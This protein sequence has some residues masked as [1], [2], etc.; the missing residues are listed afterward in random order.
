MEMEKLSE[1]LKNC[2]RCCL[3]VENEMMESS[4]LIEN[5][6]KTIE[7]LLFECS[8]NA[9][10]LFDLDDKSQ[11]I[12]EQKRICELCTTELIMVAKF[13]EK[14]EISANTLDRIRRQV[15][16]MTIEPENSG[17]NIEY[18]IYDTNAD[19]I[20]ETQ[21]SMHEKEQEDDNNC[22][23]E[24]DDD[25]EE[26]LKKESTASQHNRSKDV[27]SLRS[28]IK[29][30]CKL[31]GAGFAQMNNLKRHLN[32]HN[33]QLDSLIIED[34]NKCCNNP[35]ERKTNRKN[36]NH[37]CQYCYRNFHSLSLLVTHT[38]VSVSNANL[39]IN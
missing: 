22:N 9:E 3:S 26:A 21:I 6:N 18:V 13:R 39:L 35:V 23:D 31:C 30:H 15:T 38:R 36:K 28:I 14:C 16:S 29:H 34:N 7:Q 10:L 33:S 4:Y 1:F 8:F 37:S 25:C 20:D 17:E 12:E 24:D 19:F 2:C 32:S 5:F 27:D 11:K